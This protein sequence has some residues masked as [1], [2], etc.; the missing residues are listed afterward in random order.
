M[1][2]TYIYVKQSPLGLLYLGKTK[3]D[4]FK[5]LGSGLIWKRH[6]KKYNLTH[7]DIKTFILHETSDFDDLKKMGE[8]YSKLFDVV[9]NKNWANL[10][11]ESGDGGDTSKFIDWENLEF[12]RGDNHWSKTPEARQKQRDIFLTDKN[13]AKR[14]DVKEK[15]RT[16]AIG[17]KV[18]DVTKEK[19]SKNKI[20]KNNPFFNKKHND[21]TKKIMKQK[22]LGKYTLDWFVNKYG[23]ELGG[24]KFEAQRLLNIKNASKPKVRTEHTCPYCNK[25]GKGPNMKRYHFENCKHK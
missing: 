9:N 25:I 21:L 7:N 16:K 23:K 4:P 12:C 8:Y 6:I 5:Y 15:I 11:P 10:R 19:M 13:P 3:L 17:R 24:E 2:H 1:T 20:G 22:A 14:D 18:S